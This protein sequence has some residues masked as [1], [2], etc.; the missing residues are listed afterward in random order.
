M[1]S[2]DT[3]LD[4]T[5][6][7][8]PFDGRSLPS[9]IRPIYDAVLNLDDVD[10]D[11]RNILVLKRL[12]TGVPE[13][14][15]ALRDAVGLRARP[16]VKSIAR[17]AATVLDEARPGLMRLTYEQRIEFLATVLDGYNWSDYFERASAQDSFGR[18]VGQLLLDATWQGG[19]D[20][21][22]AG[23]GE[24][25]EYDHLID[26]LASVNDAFHAKLAERGLAEQ[27]DTIP[28]AI[29]ALEEG[30]VRERIEREFDAVLAV[31]FEEYSAVERE[32]LARLT[33]DVPLIC[34]GEANAS[35]ERVKKEA[36]DVR[37]FAGDMT[38]IDHANPEAGAISRSEAA[39]KSG[40]TVDADVSIPDPDAEMAGAPFAEYLA[41]GTVNDDAT[42][43]STAR[44]IAA[45]TLDQQVQEVA[46]EIEYLRQRHDWEY[47]DFT[48]VLRS[49]GDPMPRVRRV[50]QH[51]GIPTASAGVNG[52]EQDLAVRELHALAQYHI[53]GREE[54]L[55]LLRSRVPDV[56][57][58][59]IRAC[60][61]PTSIAKSLNRWI[62][63]TNLKERIA[64]D[65]RDI[66]AREQF[67]NISRLL[68][69]AEF[70]DE[71][72]FL[73]REWP[74][75]LGMLERAI[76]YDAPY[77]HT[78]AV[79][80]AEGG[81]TVGDVALLKDETRK[82]VF[83]L[84]VVDG[85]YPG[86]ESLSP[87]FP[88]AWIERMATYPAV[89]R[90]SDADVR[91]TYATT[92]DAD[93]DSVGDPF[94]RYHNERARRKLAVGARAAEDYLY[95]CTYERAD[96][97]VAKPRHESRY[98]HEIRDHSGLALEEVEGPG[99]DRE[100]YTLGSAS[101]AILSQPWSELERVQ[102]IAS[103]GGEVELETAEETF[104]AIRRVL[105]ESE[106]VSPRFVE[107]VE[108]QFDLARGAVRPSA[109][110]GAGSD[111]G[112]GEETGPGVEPAV[113]SDGG[114]SR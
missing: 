44:L 60:V 7:V 105:A 100:I 42:G 22:D 108:T 107:A 50:L 95:F 26:E 89:T 41:T 80:V 11:P 5:L 101:A 4:G 78:A 84:N 113:E 112:G 58:E 16:N 17:H 73:A 52:L 102:A 30:G 18:D 55:A 53:D 49:V 86:D 51:S 72:D 91:E 87:L 9:R 75:F 70:V 66:D 13:F 19:F 104:A 54:A 82:A 81:V 96:S 68:S 23:D 14:T 106:D 45:E 6:H 110:P 88:A 25:G 83:L 103:K 62:V 1:Y 10:G 34:V 28:Q 98:L 94:E 2:Q 74:Q 90:P 63:T 20:V 46:N 24:R 109:D 85:E 12:P 21:D 99:E 15:A 8:L 76:T 47:D 69:I 79:D 48:V 92:G 3:P 56:D 29:D 114:V 93:S 39:P 37:R 111:G 43:E 65:G 33:R 32:Y 38:V 64:S 67:R 35:I 31:E 97:T 59:L 71:Q 77:A 27:A 57:D 61:E 40:P 36:G